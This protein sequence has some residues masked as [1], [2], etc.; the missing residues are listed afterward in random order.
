MTTNSHA[1]YSFE[2]TCGV[3]HIL[4]SSSSANANAAEIAHANIIM[5]IEPKPRSLMLASRPH[6]IHKP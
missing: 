1:K 5:K 6:L 3:L 4:Y 2:V